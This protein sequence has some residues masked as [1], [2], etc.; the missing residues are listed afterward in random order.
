MMPEILPPTVLTVDDNDAVRYSLTR[1]LREAGYHVIEARTGTEALNLA[2][3]D[4]ALITLDISLPDLDGFE[5][6]RRL[7][8]DPTTCEIPVLHIS[9]SF[10]ESAHKVRG[11][12]GGADAYLS[13]PINQ[14]ELLATVKA[15]LRMSQAQR[16]ARHKAEE[17]EKAKEELKK[18]ND[19]LET[20]VRERTAE[21]KSANENLRELSARLLQLRD[22]ERR[23]L[24]R[25]LHDSVGQMLTAITM[26]IATV[27]STP[28]AAEAAKAAAEN[29]VP[30]QQVS[31]EIRTMSHLLHPPLLDEVG[32]KSALR[33]Y[34][35][36][37][38]ERSKI[39]VDLEIEPNFG[40]LPTEMEIAI[41]RIVQECLTNVHRHS[42]S[43]I[44]H[45]K[46]AYNGGYVR[47]MISDAGKGIP[48][49]I[50]QALKSVGKMGVGF[51]GMRERIMQ[52]GGALELQ[53]GEDG[54]IV[55]CTMPAQM[56]SAGGTTQPVA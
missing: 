41:F 17:A 10:V 49:K 25:E 24:A 20:R 23:R 35:E 16:E 53:S 56:P 7:K 42:G 31:N 15:L 26:N 5:V 33:W 50:Q 39:T 38:A 55:T 14:Q 22:E 51:R 36:E 45:V 32:L 11:L 21:L 1:Y 47:L 29:E 2:R 3:H 18:L 44:A 8:E 40:R 12:E 27:R 43:N 46:V 37:F 48:P 19:N 34:V 54:T 13:E 52:L 30:V 9:A 6:C 28:L 4:P